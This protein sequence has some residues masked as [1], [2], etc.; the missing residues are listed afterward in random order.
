MKQKFTL[1]ELLVV[2]AIIAILAAM[3]LPALS[4]ARERAKSANC[5]NNLKQTGLGFASYAGDSDD[6]LPVYYYKN[7]DNKT[8]YWPALMISGNNI[9]AHVLNCPSLLDTPDVF[10]KAGTDWILAVKSRLATSD[11][12][13]PD[14]AMNNGLSN[15]TVGT[16]L[17]TKKLGR[18]SQ[19]SAT[20]VIADSYLAGIQER[21][22]YILS[23]MWT[24]KTTDYSMI[25]NRHGGMCNVLFADGHAESFTVK[26]RKAD[27]TSDNCPYKNDAPFNTYGDSSNPFWYA[28]I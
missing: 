12:K 19:P 17:T 22:Y 27:F 15:G 4:A 16:A 5:T 2:I 21:S 14:Y 1:I 7:E 26:G 13:Y 28:E 11:L 6:N 23:R 8:V 9:S 20:C 10:S 25:D 18:F 24:S 3:L